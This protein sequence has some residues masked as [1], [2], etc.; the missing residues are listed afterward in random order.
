MNLENNPL[1]DYYAILQVH[2]QAEADVI[3]AAYRMLMRKYHPDSLSPEQRRDIELL[4]RVRLINIAYDILSDPTQRD[5][6]D[7]AIKRQTEKP[8]VLSTPGLETR[9]HLVRCAKMGKTY[10]MLL[11]RR[12]G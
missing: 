10:K 11:A 4:E 2:P 3:R 5:A 9:I 6:Y 7:L 12:A 8:S 1:P